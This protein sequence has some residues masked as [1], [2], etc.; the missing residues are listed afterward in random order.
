MPRSR[1][2]VSRRPARLRRSTPGERWGGECCRT[3][4]PAPAEGGSLPPGT[5][6]APARGYLGALQP[7]PVRGEVEADA[8]E[9]ALQRGPVDDED[10]D[11]QIGEGGC[12]VQHLH[13]GMAWLGSAPLRRRGPP[14][15][16]HTLP[17]TLPE[18]RMPF[19]TQ[20][21]TRIQVIIKQR[22]RG[23]CTGPG[24]PRPEL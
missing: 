20:R 19:S 7:L 15:R 10:E 2:P 9:G 21:K 8:I 23:H 12:E 1:C 17:L 13:K 18:L 3:P 24:S 11:D 14:C 6:L 4:H 5:P 16:P 22:A